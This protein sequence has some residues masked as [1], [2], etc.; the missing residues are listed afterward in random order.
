MRQRS[1]TANGLPAL[2][3][4]ARAPCGVFSTTST[5]EAPRLSTATIRAVDCSKAVTRPLSHTSEARLAPALLR[6][7]DARLA[8][9]QLA[10]SD[11]YQGLKAAVM[12]L[13]VIASFDPKSFERR[14]QTAVRAPQGSLSCATNQRP[15]A[16]F[17]GFAAWRL[18]A[19]APDS[20]W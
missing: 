16:P 9:V 8:G 12:A 2:I 19:I 5:C 13:A 6:C 18:A 20:Q 3:P 14:L 15:V 10:I 1:E 17:T 7:D 4:T 11:A